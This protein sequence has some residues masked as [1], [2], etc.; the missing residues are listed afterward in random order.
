LKHLKIKIKIK[1]TLRISY[2]FI[3]CVPLQYNQQAWLSSHYSLT[4][5]IFFS[6]ILFPLPRT[7]EVARRIKEKRKIK[8]LTTQERE[9]KTQPNPATRE[10]C[11]CG[12][13]GG[14]QGC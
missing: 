6:A 7:K 10:I 4:N 14:G 1:K 9:T 11:D 3:S 12:G 13:G 5:T 2:S 8:Q